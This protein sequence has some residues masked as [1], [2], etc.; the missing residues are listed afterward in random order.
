MQRL[1]QLLEEGRFLLSE[2]ALGRGITREFTAWRVHR[3]NSALVVTSLENAGKR[4][5]KV[6]ELVIYDLDRYD[7]D[8]DVVAKV[9]ALAGRGA[10]IPTMMSTMQDLASA[11]GGKIGFDTRSLRGVDVMPGG[12]ETLKIQTKDLSI[13]AGHD[14]F[15][16]RDLVDQN[17]LPTCIPVGKGGKASVPAFYRWVKDNQAKIKRM[18]FRDVL[19]ELDA[20]AIPYHYFCA[21]D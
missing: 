6:A 5:K 12:F 18:S 3:F 21:M 19:R 15:T 9:I 11:S 13:E 10:S 2:T 8:E 1:D 14:S 4:G 20:Q 16:I 17:N 7:Q